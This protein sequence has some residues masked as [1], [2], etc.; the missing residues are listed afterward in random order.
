MSLD[1]SYV[2]LT[3]NGDLQLGTSAESFFLLRNI[4]PIKKFGSNQGLLLN[5]VVLAQENK[6]E[7]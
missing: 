3:R 6:T 5:K 4:T 1:D 2:R 7:Q